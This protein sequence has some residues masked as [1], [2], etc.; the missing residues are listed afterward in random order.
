MTRDTPLLE[1][2]Q[3]R[4]TP[5]DRHSSTFMSAEPLR[6]KPFSLAASFFLLLLFFQL[7]KERE[8]DTKELIRGDMKMGEGVRG[9]SWSDAEE[10][11]CLNAW[12]G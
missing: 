9:E 8:M 5:I 12:G 1:F 2:S 3:V 11:G 6:E 4:A 10:S 7:I